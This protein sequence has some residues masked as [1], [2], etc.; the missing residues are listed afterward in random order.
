MVFLEP[1]ASGPVLRR[2]R[3]DPAGLPAADACALQVEKSGGKSSDG[4][5]GGSILDV[6]ITG[7]DQR[8][9]LCMGSSTEV[10]AGGDPL[11]LD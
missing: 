8:S 11:L 6:E 3:V 2:R 4:V 10:T 9:P 1:Y 7:V 5:T